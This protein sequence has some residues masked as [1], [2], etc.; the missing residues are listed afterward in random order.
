MILTGQF[1][2][3]GSPGSK[4]IRLCPYWGI[5]NEILLFLNIELIQVLLVTS[6]FLLKG[7]KML[8]FLFAFFP[9]ISETLRAHTSGMKQISAKGKKPSSQFLTAFHINQ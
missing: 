8:N 7:H 2:A 9:E 5:E 6:Q 1:F 4:K 3:I